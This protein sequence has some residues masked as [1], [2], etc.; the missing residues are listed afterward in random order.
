MASSFHPTR[1]PL[2][3]LAF[4]IGL[5]AT[6]G[7]GAG[8]LVGDFRDEEEEAGFAAE[9]LRSGQ[10]VLVPREEYWRVKMLLRR[11]ER[12]TSWNEDEEEGPDPGP[13]DPE[14]TAGPSS[15]STLPPDDVERWLADIEREARP[16]RAAPP[17]TAAPAPPPR[18]SRVPAEGRRPLPAHRRPVE[19]ARRPIEGDVRREYEQLLGELNR[20][21]SIAALP[22][23]AA[24]EAAFHVRCTVCGAEPALGRAAAICAVCLS[25]VCAPCGE[26]QTRPDGRLVC[27]ACQHLIDASGG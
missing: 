17:P 19:P 15:P 12:T 21:G 4:S 23:H 20:A 5:V 11:R 25:P 10:Y 16:A 18:S 27:P 13:V 3:M 2:W 8:L 24:T 6:A 26:T 7:G 22:T 14:D 9:A 1:L